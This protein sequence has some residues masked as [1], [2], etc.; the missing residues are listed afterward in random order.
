M[1]IYKYKVRDKYGNSSTGLIEGEDKDKVFK[2]LEKMGFTPVSIEISHGFGGIKMLQ[3][4]H[5]G[6]LRALN[7]FTSQLATLVKS[8]LPLLNS[9]KTLEKQTSKNYLKQAISEIAR[10]VEAGNSLSSALEHHLDIFSQIYINMVR[11]GET[12]GTLDEVLTRLADLLDYEIDTRSKILGVVL[13]PLIATCFLFAA[14]VILVTFVLPQFVKM[15]ET[16]KGNL[17]LPTLLLIKASYIM[18]NYWYII[19]AVIGIAVFGFIKYI[20]TEYGRKRWDR[21]RL[22]VPVFGPIILKLTMSRFSRIMSILTRSGVPILTI[23]EIT[24]R[25]VGNVII[26]QAIDNIRTS[27]NEGKGMAEPMRISGVFSPMVTQMVAVGEETGR[28][29]ELLYEVS[30]HYDKESAYAIKNM[31]V[32]IEPMLIVILAIGVLVMALGIFLPMWNMYT[33]LKG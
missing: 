1:P 16:L 10:E 28:L 13:Y 23:L 25:T 3:K 19:L 17:P 6:K 26:S 29:D 8:G 24:S 7:L 12:G 15:F 5:F 11:A 18:N 27:V 9:L 21:F 32:I 14:F 22:N 20:K 30:I 31:S 33:I 4:F 2:G